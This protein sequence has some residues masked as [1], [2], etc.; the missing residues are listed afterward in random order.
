MEYKVNCYT[1]ISYTLDVVE[2]V[3]KVLV[4]PDQTEQEHSDLVR[5]RIDIILE[6]NPEVQITTSTL[7]IR[8]P[9]Y[10]DTTLPVGEA[11]TE[12]P[13]LALYDNEAIK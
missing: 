6:Q 11:V 8:E 10:V 4:D 7:Y 1:R 12:E 5:E 9:V 3:D 13:I 2:L